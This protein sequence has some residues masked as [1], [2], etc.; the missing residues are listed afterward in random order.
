MI[1]DTIII[2]VLLAV[3]IV[4]LLLEIFFLPG[5][6]VAGIASL[7]FY[8][9]TIYYAFA[10]LGV[11]AGFITIII[12]LLFTILLM[13]YFM[14]SRMLDKMSLHTNIDETA[15]T[16]VASS[17]QVGDKG[18]TLSRLNPMGRVLINNVSVEARA[19]SYVDE[20]VEVQVVKV[21]TTSVLVKPV[22]DDNE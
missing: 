11:M 8:A 2:I 16:Q 15:P 9:V 19:I 22:A 14:R 7:V 1:L 4:L 18:V 20:N 5:I 10:R 6:S 21:D 3:A 13:W 12:A 17:I